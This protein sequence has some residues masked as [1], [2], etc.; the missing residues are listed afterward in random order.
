MRYRRILRYISFL[1]FS[2]AMLAGW[3]TV[4]KAGRHDCISAPGYLGYAY[5]G[6]EVSCEH[7]Y[8]WNSCEAFCDLCWSTSCYYLNYC[9]DGEWLAG[10]CTW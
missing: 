1:L 4:L 5:Y 3:P 7:S 9:E 2:G 8:Q 6:E 10:A